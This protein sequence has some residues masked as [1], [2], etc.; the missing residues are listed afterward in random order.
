MVTGQTSTDLSVATA[1]WSGGSAATRKD[2]RAHP[3][4]TGPG[5]MGRARL[6]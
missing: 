1:Q 3:A 6:G 2:H 5:A 4:T